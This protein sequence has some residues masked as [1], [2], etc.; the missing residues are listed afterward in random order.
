MRRTA[1]YNSQILVQA[2]KADGSAA[3]EPKVLTSG[4]WDVGRLEWT[5]DGKELIF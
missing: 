4:V 2:L 1:V 5:P 3:G